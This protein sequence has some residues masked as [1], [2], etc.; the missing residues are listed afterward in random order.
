MEIKSQELDEDMEPISSLQLRSPEESVVGNDTWSVTRIYASSLTGFCEEIE[1]HD[2]T[3]YPNWV[4]KNECRHAVSYML[5]YKPIMDSLN[6]AFYDTAWG[7]FRDEMDSLLKSFDFESWRL[8]KGVVDSQG[9][10]LLIVELDGFEY[11]LWNI[12]LALPRATTYGEVISN[13]DK[14]EAYVLGL[15]DLVLARMQNE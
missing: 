13:A 4:Q 5:G 14:L 15:G 3:E 12:Y 7:V 6:I 11:P 2:M 10:D 1:V 8:A 9:E